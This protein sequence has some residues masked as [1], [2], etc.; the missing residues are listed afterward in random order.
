MVLSIYSKGQKKEKHLWQ[1]EEAYHLEMKWRT[2]ATPSGAALWPVS[3]I[4]SES[5]TEIG[6]E[7]EVEGEI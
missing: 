6:L 5:M 7:M 1:T 3:N 2:V 4:E